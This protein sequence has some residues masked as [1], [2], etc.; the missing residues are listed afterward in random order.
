MI[1]VSYPK[2]RKSFE[3]ATS[4]LIGISIILQAVV[5]DFHMCS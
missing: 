2:F 3:H 1:G 5:I 4:S